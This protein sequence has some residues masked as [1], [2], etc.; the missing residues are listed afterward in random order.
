MEYRPYTQVTL[1]LTAVGALNLDENQVS[2]ATAAFQ[3]A[4]MPHELWVGPLPVCLA[5]HHDFFPRV[6][7]PCGRCAQ[8]I[9]E[10]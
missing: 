1:K 2:E 5:E 7:T 3:A 4:L 10:G 8:V 9:V 6:R